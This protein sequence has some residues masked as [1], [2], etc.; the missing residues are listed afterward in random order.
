[1]K[2]NINFNKILKN[3]VNNLQLNRNKIIVSLILIK[4]FLK[5]KG[6]LIILTKITNIPHKLKIR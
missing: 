3:K 4:V 1:M 6:I 2:T 5:K